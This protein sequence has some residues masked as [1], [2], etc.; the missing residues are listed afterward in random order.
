VGGYHSFVVFWKKTITKMITYSIITRSFTMSDSCERFFDIPELVD[1][2][3]ANLDKKDIS[4]LARTCRRMNRSCTPSLFRSLTV[5]DNDEFSLFIST[6]ALHT[7]A[8]N[9]QHVRTLD[10]GAQELAYYY[11]C[12]LA[13]EE[14]TSP[15]TGTPAARQPWLQPPD[16]RT[17]Q[18]V[19]LPP[20]TRL[21][22]LTLHL[23]T[24]GYRLYSLPSARDSQALLAQLCWVVSLN[25]GLK[26]LDVKDIT[27]ESLQDGRLLARTIS[28]MSNI[29]DLDLSV[30]YSGDYL[31]LGSYLFYHC[32][33][34]IRKL[35]IAFPG[36]YDANPVRFE[37]RLEEEDAECT[38][39]P[40]PLINLEELAIWGSRFQRS[41]V[42]I[43]SVFD[44]CS[45]IKRLDISTCTGRRKT[46]AMAEHIAKACPKIESLAYRLSLFWSRDPLPFRIMDSL[47][48]QQISHLEYNG[49]FSNSVTIVPISPSN[50]TR[51]HCD[52]FSS[53]A[54]LKSHR[55]QFPQSSRSVETW[56]YSVSRSMAWQDTTPR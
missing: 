5:D 10:A 15:T 44:H 38:R 2:L 39:R 19:A 8:R 6:P 47:P 35:S 33:P 22:Q 50:G 36:I 13:L 26:L 28:G 27:I 31:E 52:R 56:R 14:I 24:N 12:V 41:T 37:D 17:C 29:D 54:R 48:D 51:Q 18:V 9:I 21:S 55:S 4:R 1:L 49:T 32:P 25:P 53:M 3:A 40:A 45:N 34:S 30:A 46:I 11:N 20:M 43:R 23:G 7:L 16:I 42:G